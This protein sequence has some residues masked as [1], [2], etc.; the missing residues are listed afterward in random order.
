MPKP[1]L[2]EYQANAV[3]KALDF[4]NN[5]PKKKKKPQ[6]IIHPT[7][8]GKSLTISNIA[9]RL[10][11]PVLVLQPSKEILLQNFE[12]LKSF[13]GNATMY[14]ASV[15]KKEMSHL[16]YA[17]L[18]SVKLLASEFKA[19][20]VKTVLI[21]EAHRGYPPDDTSMFMKFMTELEPENV[22]GFTATPF[23]L[24]NYS[25]GLGSWSQLNMIT[26]IRPSYFKGYLDILQIPDVI[27]LDY[28]CP[29]KYEVY[30][31]DESKLELNSNGSEFTEVSIKQAVSDLNI[32]NNIYLTV[33]K[34]LKEGRKKIIVFLDSVENCHIMAKALGE[35]ADVI[36]GKTPKKQ[37][38][39]IID[40]FRHTDKLNV[41]CNHSALGIGF[42]SPDIDCVILGRPT[43][44]LSNIYQFIGRAVRP[45]DNKEDADVVDFGGN[46]Q[47]F[48]R[49]ES[50]VFTQHKNKIYATMGGRVVSG[51]PLDEDK[52]LWQDFIQNN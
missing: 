14:S 47:R 39:A 32:N 46:I 37:R 4:I 25:V 20:G 3:T 29:L 2:R 12:K 30:R 38:Q 45:S 11:H 7:G 49:I 43:N 31:F 18:G 50:L 22:I 27:A 6:L 8:T 40:K 1:V 35:C 52:P 23:S 15:G 28:W 41:L 42:D 34:K 51:V 48:G 16:T 21:D 24:K 17:T 36:S 33:K 10:E 19:L 13:G 9:Y 26:R 5:T 44:S